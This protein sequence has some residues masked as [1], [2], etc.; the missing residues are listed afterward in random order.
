VE[1]GAYIIYPEILR[2][3]TTA[4]YKSGDDL[5]EAL[6]MLEKNHVR[7]VAVYDDYSVVKGEA[8]A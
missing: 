7:Y 5:V 4:T 8:N 2:D 6:K 3:R 1:K